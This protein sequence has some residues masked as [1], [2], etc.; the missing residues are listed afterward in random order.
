MKVFFT[1]LGHDLLTLFCEEKGAVGHLQEPILVAIPPDCL[2]TID[3]DAARRQSRACGDAQALGRLHMEE[4]VICHPLPLLVQVSHIALFHNDSSFFW[5]TLLFLDMDNQKPFW[6]RKI[7][8]K[9]N[10]FHILHTWQKANYQWFKIHQ[11]I[12]FSS[13]FLCVELFMKLP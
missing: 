2:G 1:P 10:W 12:N 4:P 8:E 13:H 3:G 6:K 5:K 11:Q 7:P 9:Y